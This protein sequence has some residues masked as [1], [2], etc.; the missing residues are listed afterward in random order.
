[1]PPIETRTWFHTGIYFDPERFIDHRELTHQYRREYYQH[2]QDAFPLDDHVFVQANGAAGPGATPHEAYRVLHGAT[3]RT[4]VYGRDDSGKSAHPYVVTENRYQVQELQPK[5]GNNH[6]VYL[7][8]PKEPL[9]YHYE[10]NPADP[11]IAHTLT[12]GIDDYG[13]VGIHVKRDS[14]VSV[15]Y[16]EELNSS[17]S[18]VL[19]QRADRHGILGQKPPGFQLSL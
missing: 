12:L 5:N 4:E 15:R 16:A 6:A 8:L 2:D 10:R 11:R 17:Q 19:L 13:N 14:E 7:T 1:V 9:S 3:L 18:S